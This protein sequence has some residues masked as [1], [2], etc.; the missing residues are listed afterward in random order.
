MLN[1]TGLKIKKIQQF[2]ASRDLVAPF[3]ARFDANG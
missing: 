3:T 2:A 1:A